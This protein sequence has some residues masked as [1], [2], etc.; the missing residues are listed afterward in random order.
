MATHPLRT[1]SKQ[2]V[3]VLALLSIP[4]AT[5]AQESPFAAAMKTSLIQPVPAAPFVQRAEPAERPHRFL[6]HKNIMLFT[7]VGALNAADFCVTRNNLAHG[8]KELNPITRPFAGSTAGLAF[9]FAGETA[10]YIGVSYLW[11]K[12]GHHKLERVTSFVSIGG[13][14]GA[15]AYGLS[16]Q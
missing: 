6:D 14:A 4:S 13:S 15:V 10:G 5:L 9:N 12:T 2:C 16:H 3:L 11:H 7:A 1:L 8:G